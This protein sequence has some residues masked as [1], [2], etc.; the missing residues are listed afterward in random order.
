MQ[1]MFTSLF[2]FAFSKKTIKT[3]F[4]FSSWSAFA[5]ES[6]WKMD[7]ILFVIFILTLLAAGFP[8]L[9]KFIKAI[10]FQRIFNRLP[11]P[12]YYPIVGTILP[13]IRRKREGC[14]RCCFIFWGLLNLIF[15]FRIHRSLC[16]NHWVCGKIWTNVSN[17]VRREIAWSS[18]P[19]LWLSWRDFKVKQAHWEVAD[20]RFDSTLAW[21]R[22]DIINR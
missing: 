22:V 15:C 13:Y 10:K 21:R 12:P 9:R 3:R 1:I 7:F 14:W 11:G 5:A 8:F 17:V 2:V 18:T 16:F 6:H 20:L 4:S 19:A